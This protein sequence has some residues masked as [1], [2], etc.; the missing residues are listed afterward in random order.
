M[1]VACGIWCLAD[2]SSVSPSSE[3]TVLSCLCLRSGLDG[4]LSKRGG[5][6]YSNN[7]TDRGRY[8]SESTTEGIHIKGYDMQV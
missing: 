3:Q 1:F 7:S 5:Y 2:V 8:Y 4:L 6:A